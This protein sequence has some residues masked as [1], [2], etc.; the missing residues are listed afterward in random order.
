MTL[1]CV[2]AL[3]NTGLKANPRCTVEELLQQAR[4]SRQQF[5]IN[6]PRRTQAK[7]KRLVCKLACTA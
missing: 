1:P 3:S 6:V 4:D 7:R 5:Q 2:M